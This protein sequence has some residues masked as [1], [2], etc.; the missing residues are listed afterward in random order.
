[1]PEVSQKQKMSC[2]HGFSSHWFCEYGYLKLMTCV[3]IHVLSGQGDSAV[4]TQDYSE[5]RRK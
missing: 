4:T 1:M 3:I 2:D 5:F